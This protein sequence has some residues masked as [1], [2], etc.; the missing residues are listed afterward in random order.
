MELRSLG[1]VPLLVWSLAPS[2]SSQATR[3]GASANSTAAE[4]L[5]TALSPPR[6]PR[7]LAPW[8]PSISTLSLPQ[9]NFALRADWAS[10]KRLSLGQICRPTYLIPSPYPLSFPAGSCPPL[11]ASR[12]SGY[13]VLLES[14]AFGACRDLI[15]TRVFPDSAFSP[16]A[17]SP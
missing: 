16:E 12:G 17:H 8:L 13:L 1:S 15:Q 11:P 10:V 6:R 9:G 5:R 2:F 4:I 7:A 14:E 3:E